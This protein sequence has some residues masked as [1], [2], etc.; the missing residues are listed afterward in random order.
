MHYTRLETYSLCW[1]NLFISLPNNKQPELER[2]NCSQEV[3]VKFRTV[4]LPYSA[5]ITGC[6]RMIFVS[7]EQQ[8]KYLTYN[9]LKNNFTVN[10]TARCLGFP[11]TR[12]IDTY[13]DLL[14]E[15]GH[16]EGRA[17][18]IRNIGN[19]YNLVLGQYI[20]DQFG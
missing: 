12:S 17:A 10:K 3:Q 8:V 20:S 14:E 16:F 15:E 6:L 7:V 9:S 13:I 4:N 19:A 18:R 5:L 11:F 1:Q 2:L